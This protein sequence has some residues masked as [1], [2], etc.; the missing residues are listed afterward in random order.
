MISFRYH[1]TSLV[2][3][4]LALAAGVALGGGPLSEVG[5]DDPAPAAAQDTGAAQR[6]SAFADAFAGQGAARLY[7]DGLADTA[8]AIVSF[9]GASDATRN[10]LTEQVRAAGGQVSA[11]Y[12]VQP[13]LVETGEKTLVDTLGSQ[14]MTQLPDGSVSADASTYERVGEL[15][16]VAVATTE[17]TGSKPLGDQSA[18]IVSSLEGADLLSAT[19]KPTGRASYV[20]LLLGEES[21]AAAD[22]IFTGLMSGLSTRAVG[23]VVAGDDP[24][25]RL[26][27]LRSD[28]VA[29][30]VA[31]VDGTSGLAG[32]VTT[33]LALTEWPGSRG[34][35][36]GE[37]GTDGAVGLG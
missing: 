8:V 31:T 17:P 21:D 29:A 7:G 25:G 23:V 28:P 5:R 10:A 30:Q 15:L 35:S 22:P 27:R 6:A 11:T 2:A 13:A 12:A 34:G 9:P 32:Q 1:I 4:L 37:S 16:G 26:G 36:F 19:G 18:T 14:L 33:I 20:V 24:D 3:V